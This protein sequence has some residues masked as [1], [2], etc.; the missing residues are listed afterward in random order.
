MNQ[1]FR[2]MLLSLG[3]FGIRSGSCF[4]H[5]RLSDTAQ[6]QQEQT[7]HEGAHTLET[8]ALPIELRPYRCA[9]MIAEREGFVKVVRSAGRS[10][11][12]A[13]GLCCHPDP[14]RARGGLGGYQRASII[15]SEESRDN[16]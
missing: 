7:R 8:G 13:T 1:T 12:G 5:F 14:K 2:A 15:F 9:M 4:N 11:L 10:P 6:K 3:P 16:F